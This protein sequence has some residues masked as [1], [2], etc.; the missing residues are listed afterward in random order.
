[1]ADNKVIEDIASNRARI[2]NVE[3]RI[4]DESKRQESH[5]SAVHGRFNELGNRV[6]Y[7][8]QEIRERFEKEARRTDAIEHNV[9]NMNSIIKEFKIFGEEVTGAINEV[10]E[11]IITSKA[12]DGF[13][14]QMAHFVARLF[15]FAVTIIAILKYMEA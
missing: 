1:M 9:E 7:D 11:Y 14:K 4:S 13:L 5:R 3:L 6:N 8:K 12:K 15:A 10:K 2:K